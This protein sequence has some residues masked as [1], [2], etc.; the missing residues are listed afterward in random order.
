MIVDDLNKKPIQTTPDDK[1][2]PPRFAQPIETTK[3]AFV[4]EL[5]R[6]F[7]REG[8]TTSKLDELPTIR[9]YD[10]S[11]KPNETSFET[12]VGLIQKFPNINED[13]PLV[14]VIGTTGRGMQMGI[15]TTF[16]GQVHKPAIVAGTLQEPF[17][18]STIPSPTI[19]FKTIG[20][21][22][23]EF[24][25]TIMLRSSRFTDLTQATA[26][27]IV[28]EINFQSLYAS[29]YFTDT[30]E[31]VIAYGGPCNSGNGDIEIVGGTAISTIGFTVGQKSDYTSQVPYNRYCQS[32]S[33][34]VAIEIVAEDPNIRTELSDLIWNFF[35]FQMDDRDY[36]FL[37]RSIFN[38]SIPNETYQ[39]IIKPDS[40]MS[41]EQEIPRPGDEKDKLY[42]NR[43]NV[44]VTTIQYVD[45]AVLVPGT[46]T[47][48]YLTP[49]KLVIDGTIPPKN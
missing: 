27:E 15:G 23:D 44:S 21:N 31:V 1:A 36:M 4:L 10:L 20:A 24:T 22:G 28:E 30:G 48:F 29:A 17:D 45:R 8:Q 41:G 19:M 3:D 9:K 11:F 32:T 35:A 47:P 43:V 34:D 49:D 37:G 40:S 7:D 39:V 12:A 14:A 6:F 5:R 16:V 26:E 13:L 18:L 38:D 2:D 33:L 46:T 25:S 42:V